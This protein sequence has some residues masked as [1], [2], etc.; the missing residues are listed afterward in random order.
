MMLMMMMMK[1][2]DL[3]CFHDKIAFTIGT[4]FLAQPEPTHYPTDTTKPTPRI[5]RKDMT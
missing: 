3:R 2:K 1:S 4:I 5:F